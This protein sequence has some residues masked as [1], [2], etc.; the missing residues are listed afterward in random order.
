MIAWVKTIGLL[1]R[2]QRSVVVVDGSTTVD[3]SIRAYLNGVR[4]GMDVM[5]ARLVDNSLEV[6][7]YC[8]ENFEEERERLLELCASIA[9]KV[10]IL[11]PT[12]VL[13]DLGNCAFAEDSFECLG[14]I[15]HTV[16]V[17]IGGNELVARIAGAMLNRRC[18]KAGKTGV[19]VEI[20]PQHGT[21]EFMEDLPVT[22]LWPL[23]EETI[24]RLMQLGLHKIGQVRRISAK[25]L[26][27]IFGEKG[28]FIWEVAWGRYSSGNFIA[29]LPE[30]RFDMGFDAE[31]DD[32]I[33]LR[34]GLA[35]IAEKA[36]NEL[37]RLRSDF[38]KVELSLLL[39][40][41][42]T[43]TCSKRFRSAR[44]SD[45]IGS[46][47]DLMVMGLKPPCG[48]SRMSVR[49]SGLVSVVPEQLMLFQSEAPKIVERT[50][51]EVR[52]ST[53]G[54]LVSRRELVLRYWDPIRQAG[55]LGRV[56]TP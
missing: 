43:I 2:S 47:L 28:K 11:D 9:P 42:R 55:S 10:R 37:I 53:A 3:V 24:S 46:I 15:A 25:E 56:G 20:V 35:E 1:T 30:L 17:G 49:I 27:T 45:S 7:R 32:Y 36:K 38:K 21:A 44:S 13:I 29:T 51:R 18:S 50:G 54:Q 4:E 26:I 52:I 12:C 34:H 23:D 40:S 33:R 5:E 48:V 8:D 16:V 14:E 6:V 41:G 19:F 31:V 22:E 39:V